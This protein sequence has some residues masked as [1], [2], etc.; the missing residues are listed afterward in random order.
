MPNRY[1]F[2]GYQFEESW[3]KY[4]EGWDKFVACCGQTI[5]SVSNVQRMGLASRQFQMRPDLDT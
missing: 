4:G 3:R 5:R 2:A 1:K